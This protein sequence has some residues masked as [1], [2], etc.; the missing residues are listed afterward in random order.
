MLAHAL[1]YLT[2]PFILLNTSATTSELLH[3]VKLSKPTRIFVH[4]DLLSRAVAVSKDSHGVIEADKLYPIDTTREGFLDL[5]SLLHRTRNLKMTP[6]RPAGRDTLAYL[7]FSSG[8]S[9]LPKAVMV[10]L[11]SK[12][13]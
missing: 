4:S 10:Y 6:V 9:G 5:G 12:Y 2:I 11:P 1:L 8:T 3:S 7:I 13:S